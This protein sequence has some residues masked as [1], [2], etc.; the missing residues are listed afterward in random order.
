MTKIRV[1][2]GLKSKSLQLLAEYSIRTPENPYRLSRNDLLTA[3][4]HFRCWRWPISWIF[5]PKGEK[6]S[7]NAHNYGLRGSKIKISAIV[8]RIFN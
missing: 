2:D 8:S 5:A 7:Q 6:M 3:I 1:S 4:G